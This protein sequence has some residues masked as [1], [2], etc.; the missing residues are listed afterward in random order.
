M[1]EKEK[2]DE[3]LDKLRDQINR[4]PGY[5]SDDEDDD[6]LGP[7]ASQKF[8]EC[9]R[10]EFKDL[11]A[12]DGPKVAAVLMVKNEKK[13]IH[14]SLE[15]ALGVACCFIIFD[16]G[17]EDDTKEIIKG[18]CS[19][20]KINLYMI[21]GNFVD[22]STS[23]N[24]L[25]DYADTVPVDFLLLMD[26]NDEL[27]EG[28]ELLEYARK[29]LET[30]TT[31]YLI[32]QQWWSGN[33]DY[34]WNSRFVKP[35]KGWR[36]R[37]PVHEFMDHPTE[38]F[39]STKIPDRVVLYQDRTQ[40]DDKTG[41]RFV[42]DKAFLRREYRKNHRDGRTVFYLAQ[43]YSCLGDW[44]RTYRFYKERYD[45]LDGFWEERYISAHRCGRAGERIGLE[46]EACHEWYLKSYAICDWAEPLLSI[47]QHYDK[48]KVWSLSY[49]YARQACELS[50]P[51]QC[52]LFIDKKVYDYDR[53]SKLGIVAYYY[54]KYADGKWA[55]EKALAFKPDSEVDKRNL[56]FYLDKEK[57]IA[58]SKARTLTKSDYFKLRGE[59]LR[60]ENPRIRPSQIAQKIK[61]EWKMKSL[62]L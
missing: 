56:R 18:H 55:V 43:T 42:K 45:I 26:C 39:P 38:S 47:A 41:K 60:T 22:F 3:V 50:F 34:Y 62:K 2:P 35:R 36:F 15:S 40:D 58:E 48:E 27:R 10:L 31:A 6:I 29:E 19:K 11:A 23:R 54:N 9:E 13:R 33:L 61:L 1:A 8:M 12:L 30:D 49:M 25:L 21:E 28:R 59:K 14:V 20:H 37:Y 17:S 57:E 44:S 51:S 46:W 7:D 52:S 53:Y 5:L 4:A 24:C 16:T 32:C